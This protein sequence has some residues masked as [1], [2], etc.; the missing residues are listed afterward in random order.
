LLEICFE[1]SVC[2][3]FWFSYVFSFDFSNHIT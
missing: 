2:F 3:K 1:V